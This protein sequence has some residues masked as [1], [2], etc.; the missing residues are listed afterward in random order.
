[1]K[2]TD[3]ADDYA[4]A[5]VYWDYA[6]SL[7][8]IPIRRNESNEYYEKAAAIYKKS[9]SKENYASVMSNIGYNYRDMNDSTRAYKVYKDLLKY[10][11]IGADGKY[12]T[13]N[14]SYSLEKWGHT[15]KHFG[16]HLLAMKVRA[17]AAEGYKSIEDYDKA[18]TLFEEAGKSADAVK[19]YLEAEKYFR[20]SMAMA[21]LLNDKS[22][23]A[24]ALWNIAYNKGTYQ[25]KTKDAFPLWEEAYTLFLEAGDTANASVMR[26]NVGQEHW[27]LLNFDKAIENHEKAIEIATKGK[28]LTQVAYSWRKLAD[29]YKKTENSA[30]EVLKDTTELLTSYFDIAQSLINSQELNKAESYLNKSLA[31]AKARNDSS[32]VAWAY[33]KFAGMY[34]GRDLDKANKYYEMAAPIQRKLGEK[35]NLIYTIASHGS[36]IMEKDR[37]RSEKMLNDAIALA[38]QLQDDNILAYCHARLYDLYRSF[39]K[40]DVAHQHWEESTKLYNKSKEQVSVTNNY[41]SYANEYLYDYGD[42]DKAQEYMAKAKLLLDSIKNPLTDAY[43]HGQQCDIYAD[44]G[45]YDLALAELDKSSEIYKKLKNDWGMAG[46]YIEYG[47]IHRSLSDYANER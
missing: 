16:H 5:D 18:F 3:P 35:S 7:S 23:K 17:Q 4:M 33:Y 19:R 29:L 10:V 28:H 37:P 42:F 21:D 38:T 40:P 13:K 44:Q 2:Q 30:K 15:L 36:L 41:I 25:L 11:R 22:K 34:H 32:N 45:Q 9:S 20:Q 12:K 27:T 31:M 14:V 39:G 24:N 26:S 1:M 47:N 6:Y 43:F 46:N 8:N